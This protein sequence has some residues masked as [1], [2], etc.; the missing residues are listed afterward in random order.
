M[1]KVCALGQKRTVVPVRSVSPTTANGA[2][3]TP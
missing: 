3:G 1:V 2:C